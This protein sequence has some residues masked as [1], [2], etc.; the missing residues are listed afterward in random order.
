M[1]LTIGLLLL[2]VLALILS[3]SSRSQ[4]ETFLAAEQIENG[5]YAVDTLSDDIHHAGFWG[6]YSGPFTAPAGLPDP[7]DTSAAGLKVAM[8]IPLQGYNA[9]IA[10]L[11][12][13]LAAANYL[14]GT[15][16]EIGRAHV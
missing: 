5:R 4:K 9:P 7:C 10:T 12:T 1:A 11:P 14:P 3:N 6:Y 2:T 13:C 16:I 8:A 15:D